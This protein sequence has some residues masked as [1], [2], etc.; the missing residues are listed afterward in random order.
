MGVEGAETWNKSAVVAIG[1][2][3]LREPGVGLGVVEAIGM[4]IAV[5]ARLNLWVLETAKGPGA[6]N[7]VSFAADEATACQALIKA[8][9]ARFLEHDVAGH[10]ERYKATPA[11]DRARTGVRDAMDRLLD[12]ANEELAADLRL[13]HDRLARSMG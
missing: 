9:W 13:I 12:A 1:L 11:V 5:D 6:I 3:V 4:L 10:L 8:A 2:E 7:D